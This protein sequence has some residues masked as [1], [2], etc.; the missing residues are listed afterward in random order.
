M[1]VISTFHYKNYRADIDQLTNND[2]LHIYDVF[3]QSDIDLIFKNGM[4]KYIISDHITKSKIN[5]NNAMNIF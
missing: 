5:F 1:H 3:D 4:P 2:I